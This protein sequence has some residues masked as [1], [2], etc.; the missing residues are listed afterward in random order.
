MT[1]EGRW[2]TSK[3]EDED[4]VEGPFSRAMAEAMNDDLIA[5]RRSG[6]PMPPKA[7]QQQIINELIADLKEA[8][9]K[10]EAGK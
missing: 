4:G 10:Y 7:T 8:I 3:S 6:R 1:D 5:R 2:A 9:A